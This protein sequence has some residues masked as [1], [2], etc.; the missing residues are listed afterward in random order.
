MSNAPDVLMG[1]VPLFRA[2]VRSSDTETTTAVTADDS[3]TLFVNLSSSEHNYTLPTLALGKGKH[4]IF[5]NGHTSQA[6]VITGGTSGKMMGGDNSSGNTMTDSSYI[7]D[8]A[9]VI[10]DGTYYYVICGSAAN[11]D[12][13]D[14]A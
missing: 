4:W 11:D 13:W 2:V 1:L 10:C 9:I 5:F 7:G 14:S 6:T 8:W 3:G 12:S